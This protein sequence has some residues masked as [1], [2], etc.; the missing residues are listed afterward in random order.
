MFSKPVRQGCTGGFPVNGSRQA[1]S[2]A[3]VDTGMES[4]FLMLSR[5]AVGRGH[6]GSL[7]PEVP[8][9]E[10]RLGEAEELM[11]RMWPRRHCAVI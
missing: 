6:V 5:P 2:S 7:V 11:A 8:R 3:H 1:G 9:K 4:L 10:K